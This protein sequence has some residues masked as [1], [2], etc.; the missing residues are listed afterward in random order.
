MLDKT[1]NIYIWWFDATYIRGLTV[2]YL[3]VI[4]AILDDGL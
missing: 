4:Q 1:T 2:Y 3:G